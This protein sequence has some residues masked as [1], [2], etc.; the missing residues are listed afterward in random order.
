[1]FDEVLRSLAFFK[2]V[3]SV[4]SWNNYN[5]QDD[6]TPEGLFVFKVTIFTNHQF[7]SAM[8]DVRHNSLMEYFVVQIPIVYIS[9]LSHQS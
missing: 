2:I 9:Q 7:S 4:F 5:L 3:S 1:M 8:V 6:I